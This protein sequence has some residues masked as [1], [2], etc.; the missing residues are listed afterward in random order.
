MKNKK[1]S[2]L[3]STIMILSVIL[4]TVLSIIFVSNI[5]RNIS[6][7]SN[8]S[9]VAY[10]NADTGI[11]RT[12]AVIVKGYSSPNSAATTFDK[13][14][15]DEVGE[16][17]EDTGKII[18]KVDG[19]NFYTVQLIKR[20]KDSGTGLFTNDVVPADCDE[21]L[22]FSRIVLI[23]SVGILPGKTQR[24]VQADVPAPK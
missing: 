12:L 17:D 8:E 18:K 14:S 16:C 7:S 10:Q 24:S 11:E 9:L 5:G 23:K 1:A 19:A 20:D 2:I 13:D 6:T 15:W 22:E 3:V 4:V 21:A